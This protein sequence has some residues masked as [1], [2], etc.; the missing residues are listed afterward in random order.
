MATKEEIRRKQLRRRR[1][2]EKKRRQRRRRIAIIA[3]VAIVLL[4]LAA[5][6]ILWKPWAGDLG[7]RSI[8]TP[9]PTVEASAAPTPEPTPSSTPEATDTPVPTATP[10]PEAEISVNLY[11]PDDDGVR[12]R[13][14]E[15]VSKWTRGKDIDCF[16][17][18]ISDAETL[19]G[20][21]Y[22]SI[23]KE[24]WATLPA[25]YAMRIGY[26]LRYTLED[27]REISMTITSP[28]DISHTEYLECYLYD[29]VHNK[30]FYTHLSEK[31]M[32]DDTLITSVKLTCGDK[33]AQVEKIYLGVFLYED[34]TR[35][36]ENGDYIGPWYSEIEIRRK[37]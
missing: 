18:L 34:Q 9:E 27:G 14:N 20:K 30:G 10:E 19:T 17:T 12:H 22:Y 21:N 6:I 2:L 29:D 13:L 1:L 35:F 28:D 25:P 11:A 37:Q 26:T 7:S 36:D 8:P 3:A 32:K 31:G 33:I 4:A 23:C 5:A 15:Y 24:T 16:E